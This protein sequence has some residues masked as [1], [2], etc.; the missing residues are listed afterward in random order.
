MEL[1]ERLTG[2][3]YS[4][5]I[6]N[7]YENLLGRKHPDAALRDVDIIRV[8][9]V[10]D[11]RKLLVCGHDFSN[12]PMSIDNCITRL[13]TGGILFC[14]FIN[15]ELVHVSWL[16]RE[17]STF[18]PFPVNS[19]EVCIGGTETCEKYRR[20]G[21]STAIHQ[22]MFAYACSIHKKFAILAVHDSN[23]PSKRSQHK[24]GSKLC[25]IGHIYTLMNVIRFKR[26]E[27]L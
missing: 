11:F 4:H 27:L 21:I 26:I 13:H 7:I 9:N 6:Y 14:A 12:C 18:Y 15:K 3:I 2:F 19:D 8:D 22:T 10:S 16:A 23:F 20:R 17:S 25:A 1:I 24:L 5:H